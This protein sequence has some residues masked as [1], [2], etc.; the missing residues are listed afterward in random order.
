MYSLLDTI[1]K[2]INEPV[3][4]KKVIQKQFNPFSRPKAPTVE[5]IPTY[6]TL[7][8]CESGVMERPGKRKD[9]RLLSEKSGRA[10]PLLPPVC[11]RNSVN[12]ANELSSSHRACQQG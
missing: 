5:E 8:A 6:T 4:F 7:T 3:N 1:S 10:L 2:Q 12:P 11:N 9:S